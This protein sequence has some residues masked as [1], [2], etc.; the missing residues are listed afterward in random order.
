[1]LF[2]SHS[3][4]YLFCDC[5][6]QKMTSKKSDHGTNSWRVQ[7]CHLPLL[8]PPSRLCSLI[9]LLVSM[10]FTGCAS[11]PTNTLGSLGELKIKID[12]Q[13][14]IDGARDKAVAGYWEFMNSA[15]QDDLKVEALRRLADLELERSEE[16]FQKKLE[17]FEQD[18][19]VVSVADEVALK[20]LSYDKAIKLYEDAI[21]TAEQT[22]RIINRD[23]LY[24]LSK[25]YE[26][27]GD[28]NKAVGALDRLL[29]YYP[30][31]ANRD[32]I[33]F[34]RGELLF[35][36]KSYS[37]ADLAYSQ[38]MMVNPSSPYYEKALSKRGWTAYKMGD[39]NK[40]LYSFLN[41]INRN[42]HDTMPDT[43]KSD[44]PLPVREDDSLE[45]IFRVVTLSFNELGGAKAIDSYFNKYGHK[46]YEHRIYAALGEHY[47]KQGRV[48]D[49]VTSYKQFAVL[50]P[51]S[52]QAPIFDMKAIDALV[53]GG[54]ATLLIDEKVSF[55]N[56]YAVNGDYWNKQDESAR[57]KLLPILA[58]N[59]EN[60]AQ[61]FHSLSQKSKSPGDFMSAQMWYK[62]YL[63]SFSSLDRAQDMNFLLAELLFDNKEYKLA[64]KEYETTAYEYIKVGT[65]AEAGYA[66]LVSYGKH[67]EQLTGNQKEAW[68]RLAVGSALRFGKTFPKDPRAIA[69]VTKAAEDL[70]ALKKYDQAAV[71]ARAILALEGD[72]KVDV[73]RTAWLIVAK[74]QFQSGEYAQSES[75]YKTAMTLTKDAGLQNEISKGIAA[76]IYKRAEQL[77]AKGDNKEAVVQF[78]RV[79]QVAPDSEINIAAE[80]DLAAVLLVEKQWDKAIQAFEKF[81]QQHQNHRL[82]SQVAQNLA[83][84]YQKTNQPVKAAKE[85]E[86]LVKIDPAGQGKRDMAWQIAQI[87]EDANLSSEALKAFQYYV[88]QFPQP[89][90]QA[91]EAR[92]KIAVIYKKSGDDE[93]YFHWL[94]EI[95]DVSPTAESASNERVSYLAANALFIL[96]EPKLEEFKEIVLRAPLK[97]N[98]AIKKS[99]MKVAVDAYTKAANYGVAS[100]TTASY[101]WLAEIYKNFSD[102]LIHSERPE[103]LSGEE[104]EQYDILL[105][106]QAYPFEEKS[107][108]IHE[109]NVELTKQGTYDEWV[110]KSLS[111]LEV[112]RP[113]RYAKPERSDLVAGLVQ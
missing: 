53:A 37:L 40:A 31:I 5:S 36:M 92:Q 2:N 27:A 63:R 57:Q 49:A 96:A 69:V 7:A 58:K 33:H 46:S 50:Y 61:H 4:G 81:R 76:A 18:N 74:A 108:S 17:S 105:E 79:A 9:L 52:P 45:D 39:Y 3:T 101:Y 56:K 13:S 71:A 107:V 20:G 41:V 75:A 98:L 106:E 93:N 25:V 84:A 43:M 68:D 14:P 47:L 99:R 24:Q 51:D 88:T 30:D 55:A 103:G 34:R 66:A 112:L 113:V 67:S 28:R 1:M 12:T 65:K 16:N 82:D 59:V 23:V 86:Y 62:T 97:Q 26:Q 10:L 77:R 8:F 91:M 83:L 94:N 78:A 90:D 87:Y 73:K 60:I 109:Q 22:G 95:V 42:L 32:E 44:A 48:R 38:A 15:P 29:S 111:V 54:F 11:S 102:E 104:K 21:S 19:Q 64:A 72:A 70:F 110:K 85:Y 35:E 100:V 6:S 89:L 80:F